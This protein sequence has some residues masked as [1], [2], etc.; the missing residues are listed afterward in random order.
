MADALV[1]QLVARQVVKKKGAHFAGALLPKRLPSGVH[2]DGS[3]ARHDG[4][5][6]ALA[7]DAQLVQFR[8]GEVGEAICK[9]QTCVVILFLLMLWPALK[10]VAAEYV[11]A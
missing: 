5:A 9:I 11:R 4:A 6:I 1:P 7:Q 2:N 10:Y 3:V 8:L